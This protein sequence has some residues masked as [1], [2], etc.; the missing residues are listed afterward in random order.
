[1]KILG[2]VVGAI[3]AAYLA[4]GIPAVVNG[5][6]AGGYQ[7]YASALYCVCILLGA[8]AFGGALKGNRVVFRA[9]GLVATGIPAIEFRWPEITF[10]FQGVRDYHLY[11]GQEYRTGDIY[12][13]GLSVVLTLLFI[14][15]WIVTRKPP[16]PATGGQQTPGK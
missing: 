8:T 10:A 1:M 6:G 14:A 2:I 5:F 3:A 7:P 11:A 13:G 12:T 9:T 16:R 4:T 15:I